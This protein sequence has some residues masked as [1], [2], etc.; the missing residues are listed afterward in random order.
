MRSCSAAKFFGEALFG[1]VH[2]DT[3]VNI[4]NFHSTTSANAFALSAGVGADWRFSNHWS[5]RIIEADYLG[6][7]FG[8][9]WH[10]NLR[11]TTGVVF[12]FGGKT[13]APPSIYSKEARSDAK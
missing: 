11:V 10:K 8:N 1:G 5:W 13:P 12:T 2:D 3:E 6:T 7:N 9:S 4:G